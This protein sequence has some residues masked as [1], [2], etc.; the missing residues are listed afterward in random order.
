MISSSPKNP[1]G[2]FWWQW[3]LLLLLGLL[4]I[5]VPL[6]V[7]AAE[8]EQHTFHIDA[9]RFEYSPAVL[10]VNPGD[11]VT[12]ELTALDVVHG[13]SID[14]Y[15][16][17]T[18][19]DPGETARLTFVADREG[20]FRFRCTTT[21]G[22]LHPFMVGKLEVGQN[23]ILFRAMALAGLVLVAGIWKGRS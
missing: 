20:T 17:E 2:N 23:T 12:I 4:V 15:E 8:P 16:L 3:V 7:D 6:P 1:V 11:Q 9:S 10:K 14:G 22:N 19:A 5:A 18:S 13:L 21:C